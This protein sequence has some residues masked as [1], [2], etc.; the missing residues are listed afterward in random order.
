MKSISADSKTVMIVEDN[1]DTRSLLTIILAQQGIRTTTACDG[2]QALDQLAVGD[3]PDLIVT[4]MT[5]PGMSGEIL[6]EKLHLNERTRS[7]PVILSSANCEISSRAKSMDVQGYLSK[8]YSI[9]AIL[10]IVNTFI[11]PQAAASLSIRT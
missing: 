5:M 2:A 11:A 4:D 8:P 6:I 7:I 3:L 1:A 9:A 10:A